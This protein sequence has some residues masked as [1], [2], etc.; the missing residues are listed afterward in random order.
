VVNTK[1]NMAVVFIAAVPKD[2]LSVKGSSVTGWDTE[3][4]FEKAVRKPQEFLK[5]E[6]G[7]RKTF[8]AAVRYLNGVKTKP[9]GANGRVNAHCLL[10]QV[11]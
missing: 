9:K 5:N 2:G 1:T 3:K 8:A 7:C 10:L 4:S 6:G 11:Q